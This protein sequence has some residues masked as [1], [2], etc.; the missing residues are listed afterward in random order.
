LGLEDLQWVS[1]GRHRQEAS[2]DFHQAWAELDHLWDF[3]DHLLGSN[4]QDL[5]DRR[6][7]G[8]EEDRRQVLEAGDDIE[9]S[10][11]GAKVLI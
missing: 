7:W 4:L 9:W 10:K 6:V 2:V 3:L 8:D 1:E 11:R 5:V